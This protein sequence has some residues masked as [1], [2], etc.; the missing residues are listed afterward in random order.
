MLTWPCTHLALT[1]SAKGG[2]VQYRLLKWNV[3]SQGG[4]GSLVL[5]YRSRKSH[6]HPSI[7]LARLRV[8]I[9]LN[10]HRSSFLCPIVSFGLTALQLRSLSFILHV[11]PLI[12][13]IL[14]RSLSQQSLLLRL[15]LQLLTQP[16]FKQFTLRSHPFYTMTHIS[17]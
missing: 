9:L 7:Y 14:P 13:T 1:T 5:S 4:M 8:E 17:S 15:Q 3:P 10:P 16:F 11:V 2:G 6:H 12:S